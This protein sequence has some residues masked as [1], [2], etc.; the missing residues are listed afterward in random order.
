MIDNWR[1]EID[2]IDS[3]IIL[4]ISKRMDIVKKIWKHKQD[5]K[6]AII[7]NWRWQEVLNHRKRLSSSLGLDESI[8]EY[9]WGNIHEYAI[10]IEK[11]N[12]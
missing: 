9:I 3:E 12:R 10:K 8:I 2:N 7:Q 6:I 4:L 11:E 1:N 5:N